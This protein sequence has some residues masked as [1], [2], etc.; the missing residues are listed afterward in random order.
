MLTAPL[1]LLPLLVLLSLPPRLVGAG[2]PLGRLGPGLAAPLPDLTEVDD[3]NG[4]RQAAIAAAA[5]AGTP[6][7]VVPPTSPVD[8]LL[9]PL[10]A[11]RADLWT[12]PAPGCEGEDSRVTG[13]AGGA[14]S[15][16]QACRT[17]GFTAAKANYRRRKAGDR[18]TQVV[19]DRVVTSVGRGW[20]SARSLFHCSC[21]GLYFFTFHALSPSQGRARV[22][23]MLNL[24][25]VLSSEANYGGFDS[26]SN[27]A[28][29]RLGRGDIVFLWLA[30]GFLYENDAR[31]RG[32][33]SLS[34]YKIN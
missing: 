34:G 18:G 27:S 29:L 31:F 16:P 20:D 19:F 33:N 1:R 9:G 24:S 25:R 4:S 26:G 11:S 14:G 3:P 30:E 32:Y 28:L 5:A 21:P 6:G 8:A 17:V 7:A 12:P 15:S 10:N 13:S 2:R 22:D 23:L